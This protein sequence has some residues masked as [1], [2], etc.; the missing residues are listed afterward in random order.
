L[1]LYYT[2]KIRTY[3]EPVILELVNDEQNDDE[4]DDGCASQA[5]DD[6]QATRTHPLWQK[7]RQ[8]HNQTDAR[9][10]K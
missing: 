5:Q 8:I 4:E 3:L 10:G 1:W 9:T 6:H 2:F 7:S